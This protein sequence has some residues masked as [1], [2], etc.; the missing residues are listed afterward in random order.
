MKLLISSLFFLLLILVTACSS[1][2]PSRKVS[3][4]NDVD[5]NSGANANANAIGQDNSSLYTDQIIKL[6]KQAKLLY[7]EGKKDVATKKLQEVLDASLM[8]A[9]KALKYN[10]LGVFNFASANY[11]GAIKNFQ[12]ALTTSMVDQFLTSQIYL[13]L[14][15]SLYKKRSLEESKKSI[16]EVN[17]SL[18]KNQ[19]LQK[20]YR[21]KFFLAE[22]EGDP[23][24]I[25]YLAQYL[26]QYKNSEELV[27][28]GV[29]YSKFISI[30]MQLDDGKKVEY[31]Q[32]ISEQNLPQSGVVILSLAENAL[33]KLYLSGKKDVYEKMLAWLKLKFSGPGINDDIA[34]KIS[35]LENKILNLSRFD[36]ENI[37]V[38]LPFT[39]DKSKFAYKAMLGIEIAMKNST[40]PIKQIIK[41]SRGNGIIGVW[42]VRELVEKH[43]IGVIVGGLFPEEAQ[44]EYLEAKKHGVLFISL[45]PIFLPKKEKDLLLIE[46]QG[47]I[48]SQIKKIF[49]PILLEKL[50]NRIA[51]LYPDEERGRVY[52]EELWNE[53]KEQKLNVEI[54][55]VQSY[56]KSDIE[57]I[58][59]VK[60]L[61][62]LEFV[63]ERD[64]EL[65]LINKINS[66]LS[67]RKKG[68]KKS[69]KKSFNL[70]PVVDF[71]WLFMP[72]YPDETL[73]L[74]PTFKYVDAPRINF[75]GISSWRSK[76]LSKL[77]ERQAFYFV[78]DNF[79]TSDSRLREIYNSTYKSMPGLIETISYNAATLGIKILLKSSE[80]KINGKSEFNNMLHTLSRI[81]VGQEKWLNINNSW[82]KE[83]ILFKFA[84]GEITKLDGVRSNDSKENDNNNNNN[85]ND[86]TE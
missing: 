65:N 1:A 79:D 52:V 38:I 27:S 80:S 44:K 32:K 40:K 68:D 13:N 29:L 22:E 19:E 76:A 77:S 61:L 69:D 59:P 26:S 42:A 85:N 56:N 78:G 50:G 2:G 33:E 17:A 64:E 20:Y 86:M 73:R 60:K 12:E 30:F 49:T 41:D 24:K 15:S 35:A 3:S 83:M 23:E 57:Y 5:T 51:V 36:V 10:L 66:T 39:G 6:I 81:E 48:E 8:P 18:L 72:S 54:T 14:A 46:I 84:R 47:S 43:G 31:L 11:D 58:G 67:L 53:I 25:L 28:D 7:E 16:K 63:K 37:G 45:S 70:T 75:V 82:A 55:A 62:G 74:I 21:L 71:D 34:K 9:E 4:S